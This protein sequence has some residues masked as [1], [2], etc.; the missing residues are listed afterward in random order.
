MSTENIKKERFHNVDFLRFIL[1]VDILLFHIGANGGS[2]GYILQNDGT[3]FKNILNMCKHGFICVDFFFIIAGFFLFRTLKKD[4]D[5]LYFIKNK[6]IRLLSTIWFSI[7]IY[8]IF[9][10]FIDQ[11]KFNFNNN[12]LSVFLLNSIGFS[13]HVSMGNTHQAWFVAALFWVSIFYFY[14]NKIFDKKYLNLIIWLL[15]VSGYGFTL[16][17]IYPGYGGSRENCFYFINQGIVRATANIGIGY[18]LN[19]LYNFGFLRK[20]TIFSK[21]ILTLIELYCSIFLIYYL[22][23]SQK[24]P[25]NNYFLYI[26]IFIIL[27]YLMLIKKGYISQIL[28]NKISSILGSWSYSIFIMHIIVFDIIRSTFVFSNKTFTLTHPILVF[29]LGIILAILVGILTYYFFEKP[30]TKYLK[31]KFLTNTTNVKEVT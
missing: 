27:F 8:A 1:A 9:S 4:T 7:I 30:M 28:E 25:G 17:C 20:S 2:V 31:N 18:F 16:N 24:I 14:I 5:T 19:M 13:T 29:S 22:I 23:F 15:V 3:I 12:I 6:I 26:I 21:I 10:L 11:M